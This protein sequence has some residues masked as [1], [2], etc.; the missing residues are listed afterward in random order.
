MCI[1]DRVSPTTTR[2]PHVIVTHTPTGHRYY[3]FA[4]AKRTRL[5]M[6]FYPMTIRVA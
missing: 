5:V 6:D 1:R 2:T 3:S 4:P